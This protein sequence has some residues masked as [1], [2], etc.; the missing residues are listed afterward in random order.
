MW[1]PNNAFKPKPLSFRKAHG[2]YSLPCASLHYASRLN[3]GVRWHV[4]DPEVVEF[5]RSQLFALTLSATAQRSN[6]YQRDLPEDVRRVFQRSLRRSLERI[7]HNYD[8]TTSDEDHCKN[9]ASIAHHMSELHG[10]IL[11]HGGM[12]IGHAQKCLNLYLKYL[13]VFDLGPEPPHFPVDAIILQFIPA[14][15]NVRWTQM[16][17]LNQYVS[18]VSAAKLEADKANLSLPQWELHCYN[19]RAT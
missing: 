2:R 7:A 8:A 18:I 19:R 16:N 3:L 6:L 5:I 9:I 13:W 14:F 4:K 15:R 1:G 11:C 12:R 10:E 17:S